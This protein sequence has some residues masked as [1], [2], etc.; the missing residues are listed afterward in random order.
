MKTA[1][2]K[3][4]VRSPQSRSKHAAVRK[5]AITASDLLC[6]TSVGDTRMSPDGHK[7]AFTRKVISARN[8]YETSLWIA[9]A[10]GKAAPQAVTKGVKDSMARWSP[11]GSQLLFV[12]ADATLPAKLMRVNIK[13]GTTHVIATLPHGTVRDI[14][15]SPCGTRVAYS[16]RAT[17]LEWTPAAKSARES[18][19]LSTPPRVIDDVWYR[20]DGDGYFGAARF[21]LFVADI[22]T[23]RS[24]CVF[25]RDTLGNFSWDWSP[26]GSALV[27]AANVSPRAS[28]NPEECSL[29]TVTLAGNGRHQ[30]RSI[31]GLPK[32][33][34]SQPRWSPDGMRMAWAGREGKDGMYGTGNVELFVHDFASR[35]TK[36][37][38][39][40]SDYCLMAATLSDSGEPAFEPQL[41][42]FPDATAIFFRI[43]WQG[44]GRIASVS[45]HGGPIAFHTEEG[46]EI[47]L[48]TFSGDGWRLSA[49]RSSPLEPSEVFVLEV[50]RSIFPMQRVTR[51]ND[52]LV[53]ELKLVAPVEHWF[54]SKNGHR[55]QCWSM[56]PSG[57]KGRL[58]AI[59]EVHGGPHAQYGL[60]FFH[61]FQLLCAEG[62]E[63]WFS[64]PRGSKGYGRKHTEAI[65]GAWGT[66]DWVDI[67]TV[68]GA[69]RRNS[70]IAP[71]RIGIMGGSYGGYMTN[72]AVAHDH[73][74]RAAISD[75]CVSNLVSHAGNSDHPEVP[76]RYWK[77]SAFTNP[78]ALWAA[79]PV[80][81]FDGVK[82]PMLLIH[83]EGDLRC[84]IEQ[85][86]QIH[87]ALC[88]QN[89]PTRFVRYPRETSHGMSRAGPPDLR[90]HRLLEI[91]AWWKHW[92]K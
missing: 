5:R 92:M 90:I 59:L 71:K 60:T 39:E 29:F 10:D 26:D 28:W 49:V 7:V 56:R 52:A 15:W 25:N 21:A 83:S 34:K 14:S 86:E 2:P 76:N 65:R 67:Q 9:N 77:G 55:V 87:T 36:C 33:P 78:K 1:K 75:R 22:K 85:S 35:K 24:E 73:G 80:A 40:H 23:G 8:A 30:T 11:D 61:E 41:R 88:T 45:A 72:W 70:G 32:G 4:S 42:W 37:L 53:S 64:N 20:L 66:K 3:K 46:A 16:F 91:T 69:M 47:N 48:G 58:P 68:V 27:V 62:Y 19:G 89:V 79:S 6:L 31:P 51:F 82:T 44:S 18:K 63:V 54:T 12:R 81:H 74:F 43:G 57:A 38:T 84:N 50:E 13:G 17:E